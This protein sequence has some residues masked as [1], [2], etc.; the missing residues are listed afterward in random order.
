MH[1][2]MHSIARHLLL[3]ATC[4]QKP[5]IPCCTILC[6]S[7]QGGDC[8]MYMSGRLGQAATHT[9][10]PSHSTSTHLVHAGPAT[11]ALHRPSQGRQT[12]TLSS[13]SLTRVSSVWTWP[14]WPTLNS[15][16]ASSG[17]RLMPSATAT[18]QQAAE[19]CHN[20][21][22]TAAPHS[23]SICHKGN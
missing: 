22:K 21:F 4:V 5:S 23:Q 13:S 6:V 20:T 10:G 16:A 9:S 8:Q 18:K 12:A 3:L 7:C 15:P 1:P 17:A 14:Y 19:P 11:P 2:I